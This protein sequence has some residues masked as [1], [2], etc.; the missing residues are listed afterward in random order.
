M[1]RSSEVSRNPGSSSSLFLRDEPQQATSDGSFSRTLAKL[2]R[3]NSRTNI[4]TNPIIKVYNSS[5]NIEL[6][7]KPLKINSLK[8]EGDICLINREGNKRRLETRMTKRTVIIMGSFILMRIIF[9]VSIVMRQMTY[10]FN[11]IEPRQELLYYLIEVCFICVS[12]SS[13]F[14]NSLTFILVTSY[15]KDTTINCFKKVLKFFK[16]SD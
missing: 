14:L 10:F 12:F 15:F 9:V 5:G 16:K 2:T 6:H 11:D 8:V 13:C 4:K 1:L 3:S 7:S